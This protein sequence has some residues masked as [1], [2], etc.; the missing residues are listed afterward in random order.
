MTFRSLYR[1]EQR[2]LLEVPVVGVAVQD[3]SV[4]QLRKHARESI[5]ATG[6]QIDDEVFDRFAGRLSYVSGDFGDTQTFA[7]VGQA[8]GTKK[9]PTFYLEIPPALFGRVVEGLAE[10]KLVAD[11]ERIVVEKPFGHD[12]ASARSLAAELHKYVDESQLYRI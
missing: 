2:G 10:A 5:K 3:W 9:H 12:L 7:R 11:G 6:E 4:E 8:L 1:L